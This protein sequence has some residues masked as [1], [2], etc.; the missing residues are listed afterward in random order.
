MLDSVLGDSL[1]ICHFTSQPLLFPVTRC[2][3]KQILCQSPSSPSFCH[4]QIFF[5]PIFAITQFLCLFPFS[6]GS[7][8]ATPS[9]NTF[10][11][12]LYYSAN[13]KITKKHFIKYALKKSSIAQPL[14]EGLE[15][16]IQREGF[17]TAEPPTSDPSSQGVGKGNL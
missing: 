16:R 12:I 10:C 11:V 8:N 3:K 4:A 1:Q 5:L 17:P 9:A 2:S 7:F 14:E 13:I 6:V 15:R